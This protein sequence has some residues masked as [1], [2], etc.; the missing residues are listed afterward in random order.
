MQDAVDVDDR[1]AVHLLGVEA[2]PEDRIILERFL[3]V[4][5]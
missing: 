4:L 5:Q 3:Q 2:I 1:A